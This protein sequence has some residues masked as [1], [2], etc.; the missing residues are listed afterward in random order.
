MSRDLPRVACSL[1]TSPAVE[2]IEERAQALAGAEK[3]CCPFFDFRVSQVGDRVEMTVMAP[4]PYWQTSDG[5]G[6]FR[7]FAS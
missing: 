7:L 6:T 5:Q 4:A 1:D 2:G 3:Q